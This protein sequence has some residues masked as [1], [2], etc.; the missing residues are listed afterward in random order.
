[1][2]A[3][4]W[5]DS[6]NGYLPLTDFWPSPFWLISFFVIVAIIRFLDVLSYPEK[7]KVTYLKKPMQCDGPSVGEAIEKC[8]I[9][10]EM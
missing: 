5:I 2:G 3:A 7:P 6:L 10:E 1:M 8:P 9:L 4:Y